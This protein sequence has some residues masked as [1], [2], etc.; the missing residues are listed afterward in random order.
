MNTEAPKANKDWYYID[1][2]LVLKKLFSSQ[3]KSYQSSYVVSLRIFL[4]T[5]L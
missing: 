1:N 5:T 3:N 4:A 2:T